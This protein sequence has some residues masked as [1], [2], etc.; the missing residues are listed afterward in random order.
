MPSLLFLYGTLL[1]HRVLARVTG[2]RQLA[3]RLRP[4]TLAGWRRVGLRGTPYPTLRMDAM[5]TTAGALLRPDA[6]SLRRLSR[7]E[8]PGYALRPVRVTMAGGWRQPVW[9]RAWIAPAW[10]A[11]CTPW[12]PLR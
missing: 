6:I 11:G 8:G 3:A 9:A 5:A 10:R 4:A 12:R 1:D 7:Y 2:R